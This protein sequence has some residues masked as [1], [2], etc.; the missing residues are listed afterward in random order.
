MP[1]SNLLS[2][3]QYK[4]LSFY[5]KYDLLSKEGIDLL[6]LF[7]QEESKM[8]FA[9]FNFYVEVVFDSCTNDIKSLCSF[10][11]TKKIEPYLS[12]INIDELTILLAK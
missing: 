3:H 5:K 2:I 4:R 8:L 10:S 11:G 6:A 12:Q 9:L 1:V 7:T